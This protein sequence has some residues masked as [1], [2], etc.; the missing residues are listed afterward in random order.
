MKRLFS[1]L[2]LLF[3]LY[4][5]AYALSDAQYLE[6]KKSSAEFREADEE[7]TDS[8]KSCKNILPESDFNEIRDEQREWIKSGRDERAREIIDNEGCSPLEAYIKATKERDYELYHYI[9]TYELW[10]TNKY[11]ELPPGMASDAEDNE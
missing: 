8:Y 5:P 1:V 2:T 3:M 7:M 10:Y 9:Q 6:W 4:V 11:G